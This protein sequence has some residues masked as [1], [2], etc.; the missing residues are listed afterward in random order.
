MAG[1]TRWDPFADLVN[2]QEQM[3]HLFDD[4]LYR[5]RRETSLA[6]F[7][8]PVDIYEDAEGITLTAELPGVAPE[9][10]EVKVED[11]TLSISG[12]RKLER[13]EK[14]ENYHRLERSYGSFLRSFSLPPNVDVEHI[15]AENRHGV[16]SIFLPRREEA[17]PRRIDV[18]VQ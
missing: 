8:P 3:N 12:T 15:R 5:P 13:E 14:K 7:T 2:L 17:R 10:V 11:S 6:R 4:R 16:L 1:L 9:D 18:K